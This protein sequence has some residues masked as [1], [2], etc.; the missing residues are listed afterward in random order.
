MRELGL[1]C[2]TQVVKNIM[3]GIQTQ[4]R[5]PMKIQPDSRH[6]RLDFEEGVLKESSRL[7]GVWH[8]CRKF[9]P[10]YQVGDHLYLR[11][12][13]KVSHRPHGEDGHYY[14][15]YMADGYIE[16]IDYSEIDMG[17]L[18]PGK[19]YPSIH[20]PKW[21]ARTWLEVIGVRAERVQNISEEDALSEGVSWDDACPEGVS[22]G[23]CPGAYDRPSESFHHLWDSIYGTWDDNPWVWVYGFKLK[24]KK[25]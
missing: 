24:N 22:N 5:R 7:A 1:L 20:M 16:E 6:C 4:D 11:E 10:I 15:I 14:M 23:Y 2:N 8:V 21:A 12:K 9:R 3:A 18:K 25:H 19:T 17:R 13:F